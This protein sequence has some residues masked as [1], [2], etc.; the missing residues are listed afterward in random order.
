MCLQ[1]SSQP[2]S[3]PLTSSSQR[4]EEEASTISQPVLTS[5]C[6]SGPDHCRQRCWAFTQVAAHLGSAYGGVHGQRGRPQ[7]QRACGGPV[8]EESRN[9]LC[10]PCLI[11][12]GGR[13]QEA[14][15]SPVCLSLQYRAKPPLPRA[16]PR[17]FHLCL[18]SH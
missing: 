4:D 1:Y 3:L 13:G 10:G 6:P 11:D 2:W 12:L 18:P 15:C 8:C 16:C 5:H 7:G 14:S 17:Q 9:W